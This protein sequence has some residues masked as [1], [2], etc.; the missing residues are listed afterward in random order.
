MNPCY[1]CAKG[2]KCLMFGNY[3]NCDHRIEKMIEEGRQEFYEEWFEYIE[4]FED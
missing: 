2:D 1:N 3:D 4:D